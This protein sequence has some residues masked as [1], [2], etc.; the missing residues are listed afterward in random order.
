MAGSAP[1][2]MKKEIREV[3]GPEAEREVQMSKSR[4][5]VDLR[6]NVEPEAKYFLGSTFNSANLVPHEPTKIKDRAQELDVFSKKAEQELKKAENASTKEGAQDAVNRAGAIMEDMIQTGLGEVADNE[7]AATAKVFSPE[8]SEKVK[9]ATVLETRGESSHTL[10]SEVTAEKS[11]ERPAEMKNIDEKI[12]ANQAN[13]AATE[14]GIDEARIRQNQVSGQTVSE[15]GIIDLSKK[16]EQASQISELLSTGREQD[17]MDLSKSSGIP[18]DA[19]KK[20]G[21]SG[22]K[23]TVQSDGGDQAEL[24]EV[25]KESLRQDTGVAQTS[26]SI[27]TS[28]VSTGKSGLKSMSQ[29]KDSLRAQAEAGY[30]VEDS[31][32][33]VMDAIK[34]EEVAFE[35]VKSF[36]SS[37]LAQANATVSK[38]QA[39]ATSGSQLQQGL[40]EI[41]AQTGS[42][43]TT[44]TAQSALQTTVVLQKIEAEAT[45][46]E[47]KLLTGEGGLNPG[48]KD[49]TANV[50]KVENDLALEGMQVSNTDVIAAGLT[51]SALGGGSLEESLGDPEV[52]KARLRDDSMSKGS[53]TDLKQELARPD[54]AHRDMMAEMFQTMEGA[55]DP[56][57]FQKAA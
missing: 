43:M 33:G 51:V 39:N 40:A 8:G 45:G 35:Q 49:Q 3:S 19:V 54:Q 15:A 12:G 2:R 42:E 9:A 5:M 11:F 17:A 1:A 50:M 32:T 7:S 20:M 34:R 22:G 44:E 56:E 52:L 25:G 21:F 6:E 24:G 37:R 28:Q 47:V 27:G 46:E 41:A 48:L 10:I 55:D 30:H 31:L 14:A 57:E 13:A 38:L 53:Q 36:V 29:M 18:L 4:P 26:E 16:R 23:A